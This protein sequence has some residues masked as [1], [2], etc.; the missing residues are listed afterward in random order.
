ML[1][2]K[3]PNW[4]FKN[5]DNEPDILQLT[6]F[7]KSY[8]INLVTGMYVFP[9]HNALHPNRAEWT[10]PNKDSNNKWLGQTWHRDFKRILFNT[11]IDLKGKENEDK[12]G[13]MI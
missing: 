13:R 5:T 7:L 1:R 3:H 10:S 2:L 9:G 11:V 4:K 6:A 8:I 12:V